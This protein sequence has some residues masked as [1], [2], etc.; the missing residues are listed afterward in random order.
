MKIIL[1]LFMSLALA[2]L[3]GCAS[4]HSA[5]AG[6]DSFV[7]LHAT[8][9]A[10][11]PDGV[12]FDLVRSERTFHPGTVARGPLAKVVVA[13]PRALAGREYT[14]LLPEGPAAANPNSAAL[15]IKGTTVVLGLPEEFQSLGPRQIID[16]LDLTWPD[17]PKEPTPPSHSGSL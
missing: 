17:K 11:D 8:V 3:A 13:E 5:R 12:V 1:P 6:P 14:I 7:T 4:F 15:K 9:A 10:F 16:F 2:L